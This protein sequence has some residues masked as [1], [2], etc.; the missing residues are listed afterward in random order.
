MTDNASAYFLLFSGQEVTTA[1]GFTPDGTVP[2]GAVV[3]TQEQAENPRGWT[4]KNGQL[5][6]A[7]AAPADLIAYANAKQWALATGGYA[8]TIGGQSLTFS[9]DGVSQSLIN[10]LWSRLQAANPPA[11]INWQFSTGFVSIAAADFE[12]AAIDIAD[13]VQA[14]FDALKSVLAAIA[15]GTITTNAQIDGYAWPH[16]AAPVAA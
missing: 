11:S 10:G 15:A 13:F 12:T 4:L 6:A 14:T 16:N 9:T 1:G 5:V 8:V 2:A 7:A 3:C